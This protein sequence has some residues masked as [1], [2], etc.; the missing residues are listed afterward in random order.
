[1][2]EIV[3]G[4]WIGDLLSAQDVEKLKEHGVFS[5]LTAMRGKVTIHEVRQLFYSCSGSLKG[6]LKDIYSPSNHARRRG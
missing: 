4:L 6:F 2:D 5:I 1:M 3:P